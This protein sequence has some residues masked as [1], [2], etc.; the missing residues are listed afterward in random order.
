V[1]LI[2]AVFAIQGVST[3]ITEDG[4]IAKRPVDGV[5]AG[6]GVYDV[7]IRVTVN[8]VRHRS[9]SQGLLLDLL[10]IPD[11][12]IGKRNTI[13][14]RGTD[15]AGDQCKLLPYAN[16]IAAHGIGN[17]QVVTVAA[18]QHIGR[19]DIGK[20][21]TVVVPSRIVDQIRPVT[22]KELIGIVAAAAEQGVVTA[23][24]D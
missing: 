17:Q 6:A 13:D 19:I 5:I 4:V 10:V 16:R 22:G 3:G 18:Q 11:S 20:F 9:T 8:F 14:T 12:S 24:A 23:A 2:V 1:N 15:T 21:H 7:R